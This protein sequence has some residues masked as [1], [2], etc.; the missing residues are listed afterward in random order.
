M[1][2]VFVFG[3]GMCFV[4]NKIQLKLGLAMKDHRLDGMIT[5][6]FILDQIKLKKWKRLICACVSR[7][8][9]KK[10]VAELLDVDV[11]LPSANVFYVACSGA[12]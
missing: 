11:K 9:L 7:G 1:V 10:I 4:C 6:A 8:G 12:F 2:C 5:V 3:C